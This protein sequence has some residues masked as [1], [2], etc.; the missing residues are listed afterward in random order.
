MSKE[1]PVKKFKVG[2]IQVA[3]WENRVASQ[4]GPD[5]VLYSVT[6]DRRYRDEQGNWRSSS[7]FRTGDLPKLLF[8]LHKAYE[9]LV[10]EQEG[11]ENG[12]ESP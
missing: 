6:I 11:Q 5:D 7:S 1:Q 2:G 12:G 4:S 3:V 10:F 8:A 9:Y